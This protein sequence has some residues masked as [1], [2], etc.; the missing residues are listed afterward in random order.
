MLKNIKLLSLSAV[1]VLGVGIMACGGGGGSSD[2]VEGGIVHGFAVDGYIVNADV[3][4]I[5]ADG[6]VDAEFRAAGIQT[7]SNGEYT[8]D[9]REYECEKIAVSSNI[10]GTTYDKSTGLDPQINLVSSAPT[11][12]KN[13]YATPLSTMLSFE[14][15]A[16]QANLL[17]SLGFGSEFRSLSD[18]SLVNPYDSNVDINFLRLNLLLMEVKRHIAY[19]VEMSNNTNFAQNGSMHPK[20]I[21]A[22]T[23]H[24]LPFSFIDNLL[25]SFFSFS[26]SYAYAY[27]ELSDNYNKNNFNFS[28]TD[29]D[30]LDFWKPNNNNEEAVDSLIDNSLFKLNVNYTAS[31]ETTKKLSKSLL[32]NYSDQLSNIILTSGTQNNPKDFVSDSGFL[33]KSQINTLDTFN[34]IFK[35]GAD[36]FSSEQI[37]A[38]T[39]Q[40]VSNNDLLIS[41]ENFSNNGVP[42][43]SDLLALVNNILKSNWMDACDMVLKEGK[44]CGGYPYDDIFKV[45]ALACK[46]NKVSVGSTQPV[47][48]S[49]NSSGDVVDLFLPYSSDDVIISCDIEDY[50]ND[51]GTQARNY[52]TVLS[53]YVKDTLGSRQITATLSPVTLSVT[54]SS[55]VTPADL[56]ITIPS[57]AV[58][59]FN[60]VDV[61]GTA[62]SGTLK[63]SSGLNHLIT[64]KN[65]VLSVNANEFLKIINDKVG[66]GHQM[67]ILETTG[68]TFKFEIG[69]SG[70]N[71][72][73]VADGKVT[74]WIPTDGQKVG[75]QVISGSF[76]F[77][78]SSGIIADPPCTAPDSNGFCNNGNGTVTHAETGLVLLANADCFGKLNWDAAMSAAATLANGSC[79]LAD[80]SVAGE[81][82]LPIN[83]DTIDAIKELDLFPIAKNDSIFSNVKQDS[84]WSSTSYADQNLAWYINIKHE[85]SYGGMHKTGSNYAWP[86]RAR[87]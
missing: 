2:H 73:H 23:V 35:K 30:N 76:R 71:V 6:T 18:V 24:P 62:V 38:I 45:D 26:S 7:D 12:G 85:A 61:T 21:L 5:K 63:G 8:Y 47:S 44:S 20:K 66:I 86:V 70:V 25:N 50:Y 56:S 64:A 3:D 77:R 32:N 19:L 27:F 29:S 74:G 43:N 69:I 75:G 79:G 10:L 72:G 40:I 57:N 67:N 17:G 68:T 59:K 49:Y 14:T 46:D 4:C 15:P 31:F 42:L 48:K 13:T 82:R 34:N 84:Y 87:H 78:D 80:G 33:K 39:T 16:Q 54:A 1:L 60:G 65:G 81:W 41:I 22:S 58:F 9:S 51:V 83:G 53:L 37:A 55:T 28:L 36:L 11:V 52:D